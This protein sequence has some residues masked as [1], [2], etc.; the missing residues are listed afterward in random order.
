M[1]LWTRK[2]PS[3]FG[4]HPCLGDEDPKNEE[5]KL[6]QYSDSAALFIVAC[7][8]MTLFIADYITV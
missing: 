4:S 1:H 7:S 5:K 2:I 8:H 6:Q 3:H